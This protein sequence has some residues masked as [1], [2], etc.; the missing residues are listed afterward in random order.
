MSYLQPPEPCPYCDG[1]G[2]QIVTAFCENQCQDN[3]DCEHCPEGYDTV[4]CDY[5]NGTGNYNKSLALYERKM[6]EADER[7]GE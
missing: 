1:L 6:I 3:P 2:L 4:N 7:R 5:C